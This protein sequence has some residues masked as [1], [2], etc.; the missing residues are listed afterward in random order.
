MSDPKN[1]QTTSTKPKAALTPEEQE[2]IDYLE[3]SYGRPLTEQEIYLS[4]EQAR[5]IGNL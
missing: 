2:I 5:H 3:T 1:M 4:L